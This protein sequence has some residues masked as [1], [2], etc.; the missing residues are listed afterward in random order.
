MLGMWNS[1]QVLN[2]SR[3][4][5][6]P[7]FGT[8]SSD[9]LCKI[10]DLLVL[11]ERGL[12]LQLSTETFLFCGEG[13]RSGKGL[14]VCDPFVVRETLSPHH[15]DPM[16]VGVKLSLMLITKWTAD[17]VLADTTIE[18]PKFGWY[19]WQDLL[20][21]ESGEQLSGIACIQSS[22]QDN[23]MQKWTV[24]VH[25]QKITSKN[26]DVAVI[27]T[28]C[29]S[30]G[31]LDTHLP[32]GRSLISNNLWYYI[33]KIA[34]FIPTKNQWRK[35]KFFKKQKS[36]KCTFCDSEKIKRN[37]STNEYH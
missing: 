1:N 14:S 29:L 15:C 35:F 8:K 4:K 9:S 25:V 20:S 13:N 16:N 26:L 36:Q 18:D 23:K 7:Q 3:L 34:F 31:I 17:F 37:W 6:C 2:S 30:R 19:Q 21:G 33:S 5:L 32:I 24:Q 10:W 28:K 22:C 27:Q 12:L 11:K